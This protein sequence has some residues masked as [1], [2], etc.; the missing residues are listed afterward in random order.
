MHT[1]CLMILNYNIPDIPKPLQQPDELWTTAKSRDMLHFYY[2]DG[3]PPPPPTR[4]VP[5][6]WDHPRRFCAIARSA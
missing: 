6:V 1:Q 2:A 3:L 4:P 5:K